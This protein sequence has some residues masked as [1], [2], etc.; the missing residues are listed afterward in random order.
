MLAGRSLLVVVPAYNE[1]HQVAKVLSTLPPIVDAVVVID[2]GSTDGTSAA[3]HASPCPVPLTVVRHEPGRGVG[4]AIETGYR[5]GLEHGYDL[6][7]VMAG[8]GQMPPHDLAPLAEPVARG[9]ADYAKANRM[10]RPA[11]WRQIP[12]RRFAGNAGLSLMTQVTTGLW[13]TWDTQS[14]FTVINREAARELVERGIYPRYGCPNDMLMTLAAAGYHVVDVP[15]APVYHVGEVSKLKIRRVLWSIPALL[16]RGMA[17]RLMRQYVQRGDFRVPA[18]FGA[19][20]LL[21]LAAVGA[22]KPGI[23]GAAAL[24]GAAA[25]ATDGVLT[26]GAGRA[27]IRAAEPIAPIELPARRDDAAAA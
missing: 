14:G 19:A 15:S 9:A 2:D 20:A 22:R 24:S 27:R 11:W 13:G 12:V 4:G 26:R 3:A 1:A 5:F 8:D 21:A 18:L 7:A 10:A 23:L 17:W 6:M 25:V 16:V